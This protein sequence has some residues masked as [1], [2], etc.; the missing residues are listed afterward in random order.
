MEPVR[1]GLGTSPAIEM[2]VASRPR[3]VDDLPLVMDRGTGSTARSLGARF[4]TPGKTG[5]TD[6]FEDA[7]DQ[8]AKRVRT[9]GELRESSTPNLA[10]DHG[11][12]VE[13]TTMRKMSVPF[14]LSLLDKGPP[15]LDPH[16]ARIERITLDRGAWLDWL[17]RWVQGSDSLFERLRDQ[18]SWSR[19][20]MK[21]YDREVDQPRLFARIGEEEL[22][23]F[24]LLGEMAR[25]LGDRY[26][27][28]FCSCWANLYR[29]GR[30]SVAWHGDRQGRKRHT[31]LVAD[32]SLGAPRGFLLRP[33]GGGVS[34]RFDLGRGDL[35]VM[36]GTCQRT[37]D[38]AVPKSTTEEP[39]ISLTFRPWDAD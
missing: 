5:T 18:V 12:P 16:F 27:E 11:V 33:K 38:H 14:Q 22:V 4:P 2:L 9:S 23:R 21:M 6:D 3:N 26:H 20:R 8:P 1:P 31:A 35:L 34:R 13:R 15:R 10:R 28:R 32:V 36:G 7:G 37:Y 25:A 30:D 17:P 24:P 19:Y 39:R 29:D